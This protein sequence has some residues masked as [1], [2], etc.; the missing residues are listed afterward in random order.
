MARSQR[1]GRSRKAKSK[2]KRLLLK[3]SLRKERLER[4]ER[5]RDLVETAIPRGLDDAYSLLLETSVY[6]Y[7]GHG[8]DVCVNGALDVQVVPP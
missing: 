7:F 8:Q 4:A 2:A 5:R 3:K 1:R 6:T